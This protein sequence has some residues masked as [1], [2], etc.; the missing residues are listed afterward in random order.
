M[1]ARNGEIAR[2]RRGNCRDGWRGMGAHLLTCPVQDNV[3]RN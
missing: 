1:S 2:G 3:K